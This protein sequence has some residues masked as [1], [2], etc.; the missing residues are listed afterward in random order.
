MKYKLIRRRGSG[1]FE[2]DVNKA[3]GEGWELHG[4]PYHTGQNHCQAMIKVDLVV[5]TSP[6]LA[7]T[8]AK[9]F[10]HPDDLSPCDNCQLRQGDMDMYGKVDCEKHGS[11]A[12]GRSCCDFISKL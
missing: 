11:V 5:G 1:A 12:R 10:V 9:Q 4:T 7:T 3:L 6:T 8:L 2:H